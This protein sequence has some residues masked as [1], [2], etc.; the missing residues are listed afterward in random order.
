M[1]LPLAIVVQTGLARWAG[2]GP[3][4]KSTAQAQCGTGTPR[5][6]AARPASC[7]CLAR[8]DVVPVPRPPQ[9]PIVPARAWHGFWTGTMRPDYFRSLDFL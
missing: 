6:G 4:R 2:I 9:R 3:V 8:P 7:P 1:S 5:P